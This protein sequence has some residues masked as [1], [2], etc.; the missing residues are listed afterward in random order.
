[1]YLVPL[2]SRAFHHYDLSSIT[3]F[4]FRIQGVNGLP[5][6]MLGLFTMTKEVIS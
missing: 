4:Q 2:V 5:S 1:M 6:E 3:L